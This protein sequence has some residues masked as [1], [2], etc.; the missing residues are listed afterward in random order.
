MEGLLVCDAVWL[1]V[2]DVDE[3]G[4]VVLD[5]ELDVDWLGVRET[6][7]MSNEKRL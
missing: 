4:D 2:S 1:I 7:T 5:P 6:P 3:E